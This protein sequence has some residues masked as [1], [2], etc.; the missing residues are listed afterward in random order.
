M[1]PPPGIEFDHAGFVA[2]FGPRTSDYLALGGSLA[3]AA[4][5]TLLLALQWSAPTL[6]LTVA[7]WCAP[8]VAV[9]PL[10]TR[11]ELRLSADGLRLT[12][13]R[14]WSVRHCW[15]S[16]RHLALHP[17]TVDESR[18]LEL[19]DLRT[20]QRRQLPFG[21]AVQEWEWWTRTLR[22][23]I[24]AARAA[25]EPAPDDPDARRQVTSLLSSLER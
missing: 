25:P 3:L 24:E 11:R 6:C 21:L 20:G 10:V 15:F 8:L 12:V 5:M 1:A 4:L 19:Q 14:P 22:N 23:A 7:V 13:T 17:Y 2:R 18:F 16:L 9:L